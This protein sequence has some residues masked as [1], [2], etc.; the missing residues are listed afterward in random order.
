MTT[1]G[2]LKDKLQTPQQKMLQEKMLSVM[3]GESIASSA[4]SARNAQHMLGFAARQQF[5]ALLVGLLSLPQATCPSTRSSGL[6]VQH[7]SCVHSQVQDLP[8]PFRWCSSQH[9]LL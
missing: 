5:L 8:F 1:L 7:T 3:T 6:L 2:V 9:G 4:C